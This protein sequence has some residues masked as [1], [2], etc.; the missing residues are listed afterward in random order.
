M[1]VNTWQKQQQCGVNSARSEEYRCTPP[2]VGKRW[3]T[4]DVGDSARQE[5]EEMV[6]NTFLSS[7]EKE[8]KWSESN[9]TICST[10]HFWLWL[11]NKLFFCHSSLCIDG[12]GQ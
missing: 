6:C 10:H 7:L 5:M 1:G 11:W 2:S 4:D 12:K 9:I 3:V 8:G